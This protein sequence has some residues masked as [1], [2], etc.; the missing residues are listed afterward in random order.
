MD[1]GDFIRLFKEAKSV[2]KEEPGTAGD[3]YRDLAEHSLELVRGCYIGDVNYHEKYKLVDQPGKID[4][5]CVLE[6]RDEWVY[7]IESVSRLKARE[8]DSGLS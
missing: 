8:L 6:Y 4:K 1:Y 5:A 3:M 7:A 2:E